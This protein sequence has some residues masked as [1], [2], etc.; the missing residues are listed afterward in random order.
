MVEQFPSGTNEIWTKGRNA[1]EV[2]KVFTQDQRQALQIWKEDLAA[3]VK[4][5]LTEKYPGHD[6]DRV[7]DAFIIQHTQA[8]LSQRQA[9]TQGHQQKHG[10]GI[11]I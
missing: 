2:L 5:F 8:S 11:R 3:Q 7:A 1:I 4:N 6:M 10:R 9:L